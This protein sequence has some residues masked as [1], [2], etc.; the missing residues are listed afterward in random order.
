MQTV[1]YHFRFADGHGASCAVDAQTPPHAELPAW[2][3]L[4]FQQCP[5]C[6]LQPAST[7]R[8]PMAV[9]FVPLI[10]MMGKLRSYEQVEVCVETV[11]RSVSTSTTVQRGI[12]A[13]M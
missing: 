6:P 11:Q 13:L 10:A 2:T 3:A 7:P 4:E 8:C 1:L 12:G 9:R 5:N